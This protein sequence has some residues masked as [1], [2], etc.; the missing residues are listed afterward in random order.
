MLTMHPT[1]LGIGPSDWD[2]DVM[3]RSEFASRIE[4]LWRHDPQADRAV[5]FGNSAHHA[6]ASP[7][8]PIFV[9]KLEAAVAILSRTGAHRLLVGGGP[10]MKMGA[11]RPLTF[12][13]NVTPLRDVGDAIRSDRSGGRTACWSGQA[14]C[15]R[16]CAAPLP[17]RWDRRCRDG[18]RPHRRGGRWPAN[19][20]TSTT[21]SMRP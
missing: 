2:P 16:L 15:R 6:E 1:L 8:S 19:P 10:N 4:A 13:E 11:A 3:P 12:I 17:K 14:T 20:S 18:S 9:P 21:R 5:I 7:I